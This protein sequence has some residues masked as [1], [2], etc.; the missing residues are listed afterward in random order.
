[1]L[2][3]IEKLQDIQRAKH[4]LHRAVRSFSMSGPRKAFNSWLQMIARR[5]QNL[6]MTVWLAAQRGQR[7]EELQKMLEKLEPDIVHGLIT[8]T[9]EVGMTPLLWA[10]KR[11][12]ADVVEVLLAFGG[13]RDHDDLETLISAQDA[14]GSTGLHHAA[15]KAHNDVVALLLQNGAPVNAVNTDLS[16]PLHW[17]ARKNNLDAL[18]LLL[19]N[20]ADPD[21][22]N[23][24][25][26]TALDNAKFAD[27]R[28]AIALLA[29]DKETRKAAES[30]LLLERKLRPTNEERQAKL[31]DLAAGAL[32]RGEANRSRM[33]GNK[34]VREEQKI[35]D[36][37]K[38]AAPPTPKVAPTPKAAGKRPA[39]SVS[40]SDE[41]GT[42][43]S[44][45]EVEMSK[46]C[47][48]SS[49][50]SCDSHKKKKKKKN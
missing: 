19:Q 17:A 33:E 8:A 13:S 42:E 20:G 16:T 5:A 47:A 3:V 46:S 38:P 32:A 15:R 9:D 37:P 30:K 35:V 23:K 44:D 21:A 6:Q 4:A 25:G 27:H 10:A 22:T 11:G 31:A 29:T 34:A 24:W 14:E 45:D 48:S 39:S 26:A 18:R 41:S 1:M 43:D 28:G 49:S 12:F 50:F 7:V 2:K 36:N 40:E